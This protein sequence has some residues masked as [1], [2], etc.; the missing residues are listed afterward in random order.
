MRW[1]GVV[2]GYNGRLLEVDLSREK[3]TVRELEEEVLRMFLGGRGLAAYLLLRELGDRWRDLD[4]LGEENILLFLTGPLTGYYPGVKLAVSGKSPQSNGILGSVL[5]SEVA[6]DLR[7]A[8]YDGIVVRGRARDPVYLYVEGDNVEIR[9][10][11]HLWGLRGRETYEKLMREVWSELK[12]KHLAREGLTKEPSFLYIGPA[13]ENLVRT[14]AVMAKL[15]HAAGYGGYGAV[16]GSKRLKAVVV[17][18]YGPMPRAKHPDW[19]KLLIKE[20][21]ARL[22]RNTTFKQWGTGSGGYATGALTSSEPVRNWQEE[23]HDNRSMG[24]QNFEAHWVKRYW[25]DYGCPSTCMKISYL[26]SGDRKGALTDTPD[27]ELQAYMG[28]NLGVFEPRACIYLSS[29]ADDL[30]LC[31]IQTGNLLGFV[32]ELYE[33]GILTREELHGIE[34]RWGN[35]EAFARLMELIARREGIGDLMAE[36]TLR[37]ALAVSKRKGVDA[38]RYAVHSKGVGIGAHGVRSGKDYLPHF[39]Y[40]TSTQGGDHTSAPRKPF[41]APWG[42]LWMTFPDSAVICAFNA[43]DDLMFQFLEAITGFGITREEWM[44]VHGKRIL[45]LQRIALLLGGPDVSWRP[46]VDD[47]L[48]P[49][50]YEPLPSGPFKGKAVDR[51]ELERARAEYFA[52]MGWDE[53]GVP[54]PETL[55]ALG[56]GFAKSLIPL[57]GA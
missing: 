15:T 26:R 40:A 22:N 24:Q 11:E 32:A 4:P 9:G 29:V 46:L 57:V 8:G 31:G 6:I 17:K 48:P 45:A 51:G 3:A 7:A 50:F 53:R 34:P 25:G 56:L 10:A 39:S 41:D 1:S 42:E 43:I 38:T 49:R 13:G 21:W 5:S 36:G 20:A 44:S 37:F 27:Y 47:D 33:K 16:M 14:A 30:G 28:T 55:D 19:V 54:T 52:F 18:G 2:Y 35:A 12:R 23:W